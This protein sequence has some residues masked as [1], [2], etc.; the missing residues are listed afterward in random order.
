MPRDFT[1][2]ECAQWPGN[3]I[4][5]PAGTIRSQVVWGLVGIPYLVQQGIELAVRAGPLADSDL[6]ARRLVQEPTNP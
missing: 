5:V 4:A 6:V 3:A 2:T 1:S